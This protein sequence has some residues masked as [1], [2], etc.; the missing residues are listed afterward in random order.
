MELG[1]KR[2]TKA[3]HCF[4][5]SQ[6]HHLGEFDWRNAADGYRNGQ[7]EVMATKTEVKDSR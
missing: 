5:P 1:P 7:E 2:D 6:A 4:A 3:D